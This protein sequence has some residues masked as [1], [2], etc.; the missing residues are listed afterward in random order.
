M[1]ILN[2]IKD[3]YEEEIG[4]VVVIILL[5]LFLLFVAIKLFYFFEMAFVE[6][7][8]K[9]L[10]FNHVYFKK[11]K[12]STDYLYVLKNEFEFYRKLNPQQQQYFEHR[13][14]YFITNKYFTGK[15]IEVTNQ[16]KVLIAATATK[17]TFGLRDYKLQ[18]LDKILIYPDT[19]YSTINDDYHKGEF[20][21]GYRALVFSW[22]HVVE[23]YAVTDDN[24]NLAIHEMVHAVHFNFLQRRRKS[25]SAA[26]FLDSYNELIE[27]LHQE[28]DYRKGLLESNYL[29]SYAHSNAFEF[30]AVLIEHFIETP[31]EFNKLY[32]EIYSKIKQML[33]FHFKPY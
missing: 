29:R 9:Q 7:F 24:L 23:G 5:I 32:P 22:K 25:T 14:H 27:F 17:I 33:N 31:N 1:N 30:A 18:L 2:L 6:Y 11:R 19:Y 15:G 13:V 26:I 21:I 28:S 16:M 3:P 12:L 20:N 10:F 8:K 4:L